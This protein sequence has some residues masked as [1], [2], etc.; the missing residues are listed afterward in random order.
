LLSALA[1]E[2]ER[3]STRSSE[4]LSTLYYPYGIHGSSRAK[5]GTKDVSTVSCKRNWRTRASCRATISSKWSTRKA[6]GTTFVRGRT[7]SS[8]SLLRPVKKNNYAVW[9]VKKNN[10]AVWALKR[11]A[12]TCKAK[13]DFDKLEQMFTDLDYPLGVF[14]NIC[15]KDHHFGM[16]GGRE[17]PERV[18]AFAVSLLAGVV[19]VRHAFLQNG[20]SVEESISGSALP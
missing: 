11:D 7:S 14:I 9:A 18:H 15:S 8:I 16:Y 3:W 6:K 4:Q 5:E 17:Y 13:K 20:T 10:Y 2:K 1:Q 12:N 19:N